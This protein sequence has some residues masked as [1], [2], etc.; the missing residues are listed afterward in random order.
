MK[1]EYR[2]VVFI[3]TQTGKKF[4]TRS[5]AETDQTIQMEDGKV[6]PLVKLDVSSDSHPAYT[7]KL[8]RA[9]PGSRVDA[10]KKRYAKNR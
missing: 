8:I 7:G 5:T 3:D 10:F 6:Y 9:T 1:K 2:A 4:L